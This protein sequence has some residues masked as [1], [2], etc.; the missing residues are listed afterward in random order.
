MEQYNVT[1]H[2]LR[3]VQRPGGESSVKGARSVV[4][5]GEPA[6]K[7]HG[8]GRGGFSGSDH[9][10]CR[11]SRVR[12]FQEGRGA[13]GRTGGI[14]RKDEHIGGGRFLEG[15]RDAKDEKK[16]DRFPGVF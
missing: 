6:Y 1:R 14:R 15:Q 9:R 3:R 12:R 2:E 11:R 10:G 7:F 16:A 8:C 5:F 4:L 13:S